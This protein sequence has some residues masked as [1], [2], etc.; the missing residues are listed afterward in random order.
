[1]GPA[2]QA[3]FGKMAA[4]RGASSSAAPHERPRGPALP[5]G[6]GICLVVAIVLAGI[7]T[8]ASSSRPVIVQEASR[9]ST[10]R[11]LVR[12]APGVP[13][14]SPIGRNGPIPYETD[15][16][17]RFA[18][19]TAWN[20]ATVFLDP[21]HGGADPGAMSVL[22]GRIVTEKQVTLAVAL[23]TLTLLRSSGYRV[24]MS[25]I[26]D[27]TVARLGPSSLHQGMLTPDAAQL[28]VEARSLCADAAHADV[29]VALHMNAFIDRTARR[30]ETLYCP[31]RP[32]AARSHRLADLTQ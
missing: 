15:A 23:R 27:T 26:G 30:T 3:P 11:V 5:G 12:V 17:L 7:G 32:F 21:G 6:A 31:S 20:G 28:E 13:S 25:R 18:P 10:H 9:A 8:F 16:C 24:V 14:P 2:V 1:M 4:V 22:G 29:L 19:T